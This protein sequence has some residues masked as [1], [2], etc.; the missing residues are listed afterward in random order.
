MPKYTRAEFLG[1]SATMAAA[2]GLGSLPAAGCVSDEA[3]GSDPDAGAIPDLVLVNGRV[4]TID[5][6]QPRAEAFAIKNGR[7]IAVGSTDDVRNLASQNTQV[8]DA[9]GM[10]VT[11][12]FIDTHSH[13]SGVRELTGVDV[14]LASISEIKDAL[15]RKAA[16]T[17]PGYWGER[18]QVR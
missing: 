16:E 10:T 18:F 12:G 7:F 4:Y 9:E 13:P 2:V 14:N 6:A 1:R 8:I 15:R 3:A 17:P 5:D 11:P